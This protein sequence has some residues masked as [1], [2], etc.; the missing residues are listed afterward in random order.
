ML[1]GHTHG[2]QICLPGGLALTFNS[3]APRFTG[4]GPWS[5]DLMQAYTSMGTGSSVVPA[6]FNCPPEITLHQLRKKTDHT[7]GSSAISEGVCE[8]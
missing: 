5:Y 6:R 1:C 3:S 7:A 4:A 2:G 8:S